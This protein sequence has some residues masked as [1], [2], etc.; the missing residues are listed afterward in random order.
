MF[1]SIYR[2]LKDLYGSSLASYLDGTASA[3]QTG[4]MFVSI[5]LSMLAVTAVI[6]VLFYFVV[7][8]PNLNNLGSWLTFLAINA[9]LNLLIGWRWVVGDYD[10][11]KM[12]SIDPATG[13]NTPLPVTADEMIGFG[14]ANAILSVVFFIIFSYCVKWWS[15]NCSRAPF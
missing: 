13:L 8:H 7:N 6:V 3:M 2:L 5:G 11:G 10:D 9:A 15:T 4:D 14:I 1:S 12:V